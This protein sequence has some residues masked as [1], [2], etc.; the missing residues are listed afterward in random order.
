MILPI[1]ISVSVAPV[2]YFFWASAL[3]VV[4]ANAIA[5]VASAAILNPCRKSISS[6]LAPFEF[7][8]D[9]LGQYG[10]LPGAV[11]HQEDDK[12]QEDTEHRARQALGDSFRDVRN[13]DDE[14]GS[15]DRSGQ[16]AD[17]A[18]HHAEE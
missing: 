3:P 10:H 16:P 14:G 18:D 13:E 17:A 6:P 12:E 7:A 11:R 9:L 8:D 15:H 4:A 2:S 5:A 1:L